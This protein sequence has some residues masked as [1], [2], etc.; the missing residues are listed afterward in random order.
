MVLH[1]LSLANAYGD[2]A[3]LAGNVARP[4]TT[5]GNSPA[6]E[7]E[8]DFWDHIDYVVNLAE[9]KGMYMAM[10]PVWGSN[11][12]SGRVSLDQATAYATWLAQRYADHP[13]VIWLNGGDTRGSQQT[14]IW[15]AIGEQLH[16]HTS[17]QLITFHPFG[18]TQ[19]SGWF[20]EAKWL[21]FNMFQ[22]GHRRYDQDDTE[23]AYGE[24]NWRYV[25]DDYALS[26]IKPTL[27]GEPSYEGIPQGLHDPAEPYWDDDDV[28]RYAYWSVFAGGCGFTY[29]HSAVM[30][31]HRPGDE[32]PSYG[33]REYWT[34]A[35]DAPGATQM[36]HLKKLMLSLPYADRVPDQSLIASAQG[37]RYEYQVATRGQ[38]YALIYTHTGR[39]LSVGMGKIAGGEVAALWFDPRNG[40]RR[41]I[42]IFENAGV[43][44]FDPPGQVEAGNDWVLILESMDK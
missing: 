8:Y 6:S 35:L 2:S 12:R 44:V 31:M 4:R 11:V 23:L 19:S 3:L 10:V 38:R 15:N 34:E 33:V 21:D 43:Q 28:R 42:G 25:R 5:P 27:D 20:H 39:E 37:K 1:E 32:N 9:Q 22:S 17:R 14:E 40:E 30:Q 13:N 7:E 24:D 26:P 41:P 18:R 16:Q 29:G 36:Q